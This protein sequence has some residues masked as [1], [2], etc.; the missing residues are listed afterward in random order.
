MANFCGYLKSVFL[1]KI[2]KLSVGLAGVHSARDECCHAKK[3]SMMSS[4]HRYRSAFKS[5][6]SVITIQS[7]AGLHHKSCLEPEVDTA[8]FNVKIQLYLQHSD[9]SVT[10]RCVK[11]I[12]NYLGRILVLSPQTARTCIL[13]LRGRTEH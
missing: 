2:N 1:A 6:S 10:R 5:V 11:L 13:F 3:W 8:I 7:I 12:K 4:Q 9:V